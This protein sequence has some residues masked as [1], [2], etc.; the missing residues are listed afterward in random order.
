MS[1]LYLFD[2]NILVHLVRESLIGDH[3]RRTYQPLITDPLPLISVVSEGELRSLAHQWQWGQR[4]I[5]QMHFSL[6]HLSRIQVD[7][8]DV[9]ELMQ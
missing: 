2:T 1:D 8:E 6:R 5:S 4:K 9:F 7:Q 3:I